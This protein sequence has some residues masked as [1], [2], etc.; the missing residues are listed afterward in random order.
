M[1][2]VSEFLRAVWSLVRWGDASLDEHDRRQE[3]C[4]GCEHLRVKPVGIFCGACGCP[5][6]PVADM[7]TKWRL[8]DLECPLDPPKW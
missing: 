4:M 5:E 8:P 6:W 2:K 3:I 1:R 7:R